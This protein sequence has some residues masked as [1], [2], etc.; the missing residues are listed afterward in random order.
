MSTHYLRFVRF[1]SSRAHTLTHTHA[2]SNRIGIALVLV[3]IYTVHVH[4]YVCAIVCNACMYRH[5]VCMIWCAVVDFVL[6]LVDHG[7]CMCA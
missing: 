3:S 7:R 5:I 2:R 1:I 4:L 6:E